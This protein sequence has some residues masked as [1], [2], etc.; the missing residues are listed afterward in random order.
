MRLESNDR[1]PFFRGVVSRLIGHR[2]L[3]FSVSPGR[4]LEQR[5]PYCIS[6]R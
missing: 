5:A 4:L 2:E 6:Y 1:S 3:T